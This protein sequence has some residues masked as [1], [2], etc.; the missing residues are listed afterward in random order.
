MRNYLHNLYDY[1]GAEQITARL[2]PE[3]RGETQDGL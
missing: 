3:K 2:K 1:T